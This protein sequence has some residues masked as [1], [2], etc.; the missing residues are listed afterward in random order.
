MVGFRPALST[1]DAML[2][3]KRQ[4]IDEDTRDTRGILALDL[5]KAFDN[6]SHRFVLNAISD[7]G[8]G[9]RFHAYVSSFLR[10][11]EATVK[12]GQIKSKEF[13]LGARGTPGGAVISPLLFNIAMKG[14]SDRL[15]TIRGTGHALYADDMTVWC[16]GGS[17]AAVERA[18]QEALDITEHLLLD[19][20]LSL[21]PTKSELLW[22][23]PT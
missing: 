22:H 23:R 7:L 21:S 8:L 9:P 12:I 1:Q 3:I 16:M 17:D 5:S 6:I 19:T 15:A 10:D 4:I 13:T 14:L 2:L 11:L 18:L 20:G